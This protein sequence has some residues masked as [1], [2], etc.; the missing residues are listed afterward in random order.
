MPD[1]LSLSQRL[2]EQLIA[3]GLTVATAE[4]CTG[5]G[6]GARLTDLAGSSAWF[7]GGIISYTNEAK[8]N[9]LGVSEANLIE[10]GAVSEQVVLEMAAGACRQLGT[11]LAVAVS[12]VAGPDGGSAEKPVGTVWIAWC[13]AQESAAQ[14]S[15]TA[16]CFHFPG[17]RNDVRDATI[18]AA[19]S[20]LLSHI[21]EPLSG[22]EKAPN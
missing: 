3:K 8:Q 4:S 14:T 6:I 12:G 15:T 1:I 17:N 11:D 2:A 19:L 9:L 20:G 7:S 22:V 16:R 13:W 18:E 5:G 10:H 21:S